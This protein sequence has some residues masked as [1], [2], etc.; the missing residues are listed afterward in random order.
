[1]TKR[2]RRKCLNCRRLFRPDPRNVRH[3]RYCSA[4]PAARRARRRARRAGCPNPRTATTSAAPSMW[5]G[6]KPGGRRIPAM[7][8]GAGLRYKITR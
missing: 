7:G 1:M 4:H 2:R 8:D 6:Y 5:P 3:Q